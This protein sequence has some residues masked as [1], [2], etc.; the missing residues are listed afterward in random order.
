MVI[1]PVNQIL[2]DQRHVLSID[3][4]E[5]ISVFICYQVF[6]FYLNFLIHILGSGTRHYLVFTSEDHKHGSLGFDSQVLFG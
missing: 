5:M 4:H 2:R 1:E 6:V 3:Y